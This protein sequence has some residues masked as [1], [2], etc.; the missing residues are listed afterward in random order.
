MD[1]GIVDP[2]RVVVTGGSHGGFLTLHLIG[3]YPVGSM[4]F[5]RCTVI[6]YQFHLPGDN[7][8]YVDNTRRLILSYGSG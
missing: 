4:K 3:Q 7:R 2:D 1:S 5:T 6:S 8:I